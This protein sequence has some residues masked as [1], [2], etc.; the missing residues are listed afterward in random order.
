MSLQAQ[1]FHHLS[2]SAVQSNRER[3]PPATRHGSPL[4]DVQAVP[5]GEDQRLAFG[6]R[7]AFDRLLDG[8]PGGYGHGRVDRSGPWDRSHERLSPLIGPAAVRK[9]LACHVEEPG[10]RLGRHGFK[11][12]TR[13]Q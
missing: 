13:D 12:P 1:L 7:K 6:W 9:H 10:K 8:E 4:P 2:P 5:Y 11:L 3:G